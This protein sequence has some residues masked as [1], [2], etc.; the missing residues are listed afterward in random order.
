MGGGAWAQYSDV[1]T[2][3]KREGGGL[4]WTKRGCQQDIHPAPVHS[5]REI[6]SRVH[7]TFCLFV[8]LPESNV[9]GR[10]LN[11]GNATPVG[12]N[13]ATSMARTIS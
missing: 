2:W 7:I 13:F 12:N 11:I 9:L 4:S 6:S 1:A 3:T 10:Y 8:R 5:R